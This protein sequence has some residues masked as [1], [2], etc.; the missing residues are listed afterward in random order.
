MDTSFMRT[1]AHVDL[2]A[3]AHNMK[4]VRKLVNPGTK[5]MAIIKA[6]AYGHGAVKVA[7]RLEAESLVDAYGVAIV[8][9][10]VSLRI[11]GITRPILLL[12]Y[13]AP[14]ELPD[15]VEYDLTQTV[16]SYDMAQALSRICVEKGKPASINL[17]LDTGMGRIGFIPSDES[18]DEII[19]IS[20]L[21]GL[22]ITGA[23]SHLACADET[24]KASALKQFDIFTAF[25]DRIEAAGIHIPCRHISNSAAIIDLPQMNLD[26]VRSGIITYGMYPSEE[27]DKDRIKLIPALSWKSHVS[28]VKTV[29]P[30]TTISYGATFTASERMRI[31]TVP[32]GYADGYPRQLSN[33]GRVLINGEYAQILGRICMDQF[34]VDVTSIPDVKVGDRVTLVGQDGE[35][36]IPIE[37][38]ANL[39]GSFNY[40]FACNIGRRVER[41]Y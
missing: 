39:S 1:E 25:V 15:V 29:E 8:K 10:G 40:E 14:E 3:I 17:K 22:K 24:D 4:E 19:R 37:E 20:Q 16:F 33:R 38:P 26:M 30:G 27:V 5:V 18:L 32:V 13:S 31:A 28:F 7:H 12:G 35:R 21:K 41:S 23:F 34:M 36:M 2:E 11:A 9:E 6:D